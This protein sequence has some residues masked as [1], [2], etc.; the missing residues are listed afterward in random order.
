[1]VLNFFAQPVKFRME[2]LHCFRLIA[3]VAQELSGTECVARR[4][5]QVYCDNLMAGVF[6]GTPRHN[7]VAA[8]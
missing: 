4:S 7:F 1:M 6:A 8:I 5:P 2:S 3:I